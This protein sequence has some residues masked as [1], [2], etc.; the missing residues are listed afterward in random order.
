MNEISSLLV[1]FSMPKRIAKRRF[2]PDENVKIDGRIAITISFLLS[3]V[4]H[5]K[6]EDFPWCCKN[7]SIW[8]N[9]C[10]VW[11]LVGSLKKE[12]KTRP[13]SQSKQ[14]KLFFSFLSSRQNQMWALKHRL[15]SN[16]S[17]NYTNGKTFRLYLFVFPSPPSLNSA[18]RD[19]LRAILG[20]FLFF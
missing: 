3:L 2:R 16:N 5:S 9:L 17:K 15:C 11:M 13:N 18:S 7:Y 4:A 10:V 1:C 20:N 6:L 14:T 12:N 8:N 19:L